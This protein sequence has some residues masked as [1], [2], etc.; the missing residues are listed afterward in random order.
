[1]Q[2]SVVFVLGGPGAGKGTQCQRI[3]QNYGYVHLSAGD[4][5][6]EERNNP[7]SKYGE[8]IENY[9]REGKIVPVE[10]TCSLLEAAMDASGKEKFLIDG[11]PRN[12]NNLDGWQKAMAGKVRLQFVLFFDCPLEVCTERC[13]SRGAG[14]SDD[15]MESLR[16][17][18]NTYLNETKPIIEHYED[19]SLVRRIDATRGVEKVYEDVRRIFEEPN[20]AGGDK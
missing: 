19:L 14:R 15:N 6:R 12:Q 18:F 17:R 11:F 20:V 8:L 7:G 1:M 10:I 13:L 2:P 16:K 4:L 9:I 3:V 5:L